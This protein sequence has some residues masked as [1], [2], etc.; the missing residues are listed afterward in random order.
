MA[1]QIPR[2]LLF[3]AILLLGCLAAAEARR[4]R[5]SSTYI[6]TGNTVYVNLTVTYGFW[7]PDCTQRQVWLL[8][9]SSPLR[10]SVTACHL[11]SLRHQAGVSLGLSDSSV[12]LTL[13]SP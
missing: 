4:V 10:H 5:E 6:P 2:R 11:L 1:L 7:A 3:G 9:G 13:I 12:C 8:L